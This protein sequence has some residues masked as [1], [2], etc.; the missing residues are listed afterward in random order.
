MYG[1]HSQVA[2]ASMVPLSA[3]ALFTVGWIVMAIITI[4]F[5]VAAVAQLLRPVTGEL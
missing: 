2:T 3:G 1:T 5:L 4:A